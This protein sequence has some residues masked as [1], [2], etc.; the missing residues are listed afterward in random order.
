[1][2]VVTLWRGFFTIRRQSIQDIT[3]LYGIDWKGCQTE[4]NIN[5]VDLLSDAERTLKFSRT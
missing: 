4:H 2:E 5:N 1:M 3:V